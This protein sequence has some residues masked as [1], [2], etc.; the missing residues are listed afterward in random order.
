MDHWYQ[1]ISKLKLTIEYN[2]VLDHRHYGRYENSMKNARCLT[3]AL[4][5]EKVL[6]DNEKIESHCI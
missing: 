4:I 6:M 5:E 2:E 3:N 1:D